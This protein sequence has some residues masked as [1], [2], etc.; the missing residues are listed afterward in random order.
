MIVSNAESEI[1]DYMAWCK[2]KRESIE[3]YSLYIHGF[4]IPEIQKQREGG[5]LSKGKLISI[6]TFQKA[7]KRSKALMATNGSTKASL[8]R[9][10]QLVEQV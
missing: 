1:E 5:K 6:L 10:E 9:K 8:I 3:N 4:L 7:K 2:Q